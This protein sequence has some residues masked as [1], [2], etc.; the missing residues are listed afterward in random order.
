[1]FLGPKTLCINNRP[2]TFSPWEKYFSPTMVTLV[3]E[4]GVHDYQ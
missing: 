4:G 3:G 1:M 2:T